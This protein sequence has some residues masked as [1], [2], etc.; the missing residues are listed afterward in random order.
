MI[1]FLLGSG[2][3]VDE[4]ANLMLNDIDFKK[5]EIDNVCKVN[6]QDFI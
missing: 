1:S 2:A 6:K 5:G 4:I 3:Q